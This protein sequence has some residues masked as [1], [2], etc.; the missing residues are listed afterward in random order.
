MGYW[1]TKAETMPRDRLEAWQWQRL[2][3]AA[4]HARRHSPFWAGRIPEGL[5]SPEDFTARVPLLHKRDLLGAQAQSPPYGTWP[6]I[7]PAE[8][9]RHHQTSGTSGNPPI[10]SIDT[11]RDWVWS[12]DTFCTALYANGVRS[13]QRGMVCF[14]Y[15]LFAGFWGMHYALERMGCTVFPSA[16]LDST[17]RIDLLLEHRIEVLG[18]TPSYA[19]RLIEVAREMGVDLAREANVRVILAGAEPRSDLTTTTIERAFGARVFNAA[20]TTEYGGVFMFECP[21]RR[22]AC[23]IIEPSCYDEVLSPDTGLPVPYGEEGVRVTSGLS[24]EGVQLFRHWTEDVVVK[25]PHSVCGCG[26]T[27]D[28]YDGGILRRVDDMCKVR[29]VSVTP[30]MIEDVVRSLPGINEFQASIRTIRG[31]DTV[32]LR[33]DA[34]DPG[35]ESGRTLRGHLVERFKREIGIRPEVELAVPGSLPRT[36]WKATRLHDERAHRPAHP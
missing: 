28:F 14:G 34:G 9:I 12:T 11:A 5:E 6:S 16:G 29:G 7:D 35:G 20:G 4:E 33:I 21:H 18:L 3:R 32:H 19:L 31:L 1:N 24:R 27:W 22:N 23:H 17:S 30:V 13:G 2:R 15:G 25:L 26:R 36:E 8:G 10:R